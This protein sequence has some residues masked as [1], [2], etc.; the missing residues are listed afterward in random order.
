MTRWLAP[1][2]F[3]VV[4]IGC[5]QTKAPAPEVA[6]T[7][8]VEAPKVPTPEIVGLAELRE[9]QTQVIEQV[10]TRHGVRAESVKIRLDDAL[11]LEVTGP[12]GTK[13]S[14]KAPLFPRNWSQT[15]ITRL[16]T[17]SGTS[18][19]PLDGRR[20]LTRALACRISLAGRIT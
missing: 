12:T 5:D 2:A 4:V 19:R 14:R 15:S 11:N 16:I 17:A 20:D 9:T 13:C 3:L 8:A 10:L 7:T 1:L 18:R 6:A